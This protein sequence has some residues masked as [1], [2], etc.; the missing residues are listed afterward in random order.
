MRRPRSQDRA[1]R[2]RS[3]ER[4]GRS[5]R[6]GH[7]RQSR[8]GQQDPGDPE[9]RPLFVQLDLERGHG[10]LDPDGRPHRRHQGQLV[11]PRLHADFRRWRVPHRAP[12][13]SAERL[14][15]SGHF[16]QRGMEDGYRRLLIPRGNDLDDRLDALDPRE[17]RAQG[18]LGLRGQDPEIRD[19]GGG[20]SQGGLLAR[21]LPGPARGLSRLLQAG[22]SRQHPRSRERARCALS[23]LHL[24]P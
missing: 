18:G 7:R 10:R 4:N 3:A 24:H 15:L 19:P 5:A 8:R 12:S 23:D 13:P 1:R 21:G 22:G 14:F 6:Q 11:L 2:G 9:Q 20:A 17:R 16:S